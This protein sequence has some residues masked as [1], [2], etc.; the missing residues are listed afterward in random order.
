MTLPPKTKLEVLPVSL[1]I[2]DT[3]DLAKFRTMEQYR[4]SVEARHIAAGVRGKGTKCP[5]KL[6]MSEATG[7][8]DCGAMKRHLRVGLRSCPVPPE[9]TDF[10]H[11]FDTGLPVEPFTFTLHVPERGFVVPLGWSFI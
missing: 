9:V 4:V 11:R 8:D 5:V 3:D 6:A 10:I 2:Y 7:R 1:P